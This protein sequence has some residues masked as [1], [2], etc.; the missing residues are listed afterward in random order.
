MEHNRLLDAAASFVP[1]ALMMLILGTILLPI[2]LGL[3]GLSLPTMG[4]VI[5]ALSLGVAGVAAWFFPV[6]A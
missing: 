6:E 5:G 4:A 1:Y 2:P 3:M